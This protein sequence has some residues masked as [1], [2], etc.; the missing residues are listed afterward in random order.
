L[1]GWPEQRMSH[2]ILFD[3]QCVPLNEIELMIN[4]YEDL[5]QRHYRRH[6]AALLS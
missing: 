6:V 2:G 4:V 5:R 1:R 3:D